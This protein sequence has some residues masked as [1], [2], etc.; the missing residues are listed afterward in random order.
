MDRDL[1]PSDGPADSP[2]DARLGELV[3]AVAGDWTVPPQRLGQPTWRD[4]VETDRRGSGSEGRRW[5]WRVAGAGVTALVATVV[6]SVVAVYLTGPRPDQ[7]GLGASASPSD[8]TAP[9][10]PPT[11]SASPVT[12]PPPELLHVPLP[13][14]FRDGELPSVTSVLL[15]SGEGVPRLADLATGT[16]QL[17]PLFPGGDVGT[18]LP[19]PGGGWVCVCH[20]YTA[21]GSG[22]P[23]GLAIVLSAVDGAGKTTATTD[24]RTVVSTSEETSSDF[25]Q[26]DARVS[27]SPDG[28]FAFIGWSGRT[29]TGWATGV[30]V[31]DLASL[32]VVD[33]I[34]LP[35]RPRA[36]G[37]IPQLVQSAPSVS[38][39]FDGERVLI[40]ADW[41][42]EDP[43][44]STPA[45]G[46]ERWS[47]TLLDGRLTALTRSGDR[48]NDDGCGEWE[49]GL[50]DASSYFVACIDQTG[51]VHVARFALDGSQIDEAA[52]GS[53]SGFG[54]YSTQKGSRLFLWD[55]Q[56][57][58]LVRYDLKTG[59]ADRVAV[60][61][62]AGIGGPSDMVTALGHLVGDWLV[63][64]A[65]AKIWLQPA[66]AISPDGTRLY[67]L[68]IDGSTESLGSKGI[69][70]FDIGGPTMSYLDHWEPTADFVSVAISGDGAFVYASG[71]AGVD[72][73]GQQAP[74]AQ[75]S[76]TVYDI[77]HRSIR[78]IAG[79][80]GAEG[81]LLFTGPILQ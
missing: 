14:L 53:W 52:V 54:V 79:Q 11:G 18:V 21:L 50:I 37:S 15:Q 81:A 5:F 8:G 4:R 49:R 69:F 23:T 62:T 43:S 31:V 39:L 44:T 59:V 77:S 45:S 76:V 30:D 48:S 55:P 16:L 27:G 29:Q 19:R 17:D 46:T 20:S 56:T 26:V 67:A 36:N 58:T 42:M 28:R 2:D 61:D 72:A 35:E 32:T 60:P 40:S 3:K 13:A 38:Q 25:M 66:I 70:V 1:T 80:L 68:G 10:R 24:V 73:H 75:S 78:L 12:S 41:Y 71:M 33:T 63:P 64:S 7:G 34:G 51:E 6:L 57:Q 74:S 9:S 47:A 65:T 22:T